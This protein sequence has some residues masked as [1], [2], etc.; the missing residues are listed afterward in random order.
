MNILLPVQSWES[1][2]LGATKTKKGKLKLEL[3]F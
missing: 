1:V 3:L 2:S